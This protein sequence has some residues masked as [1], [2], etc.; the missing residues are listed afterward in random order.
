MH[1]SEFVIKNEIHKILWDFEI[2]T[3]HQILFRKPDLVL[4]RRKEFVI[5]DFI[6]MSQKEK[7]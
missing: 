6:S 4:T 1:K 7:K 2:E 5:V 3:D